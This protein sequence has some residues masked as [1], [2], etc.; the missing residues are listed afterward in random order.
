M[1]PRGAPYIGWSDLLAAAVNCVVPGDASNAQ[2]TIEALWAPN[3]VACLSV[4]SGLDALFQVLALPP[5]SEIIVSAITIPHIL[6]IIAKHDLIA[7]PIDVDMD[8][9]AVDADAVRGAVTGKTKA[10][11]V[12]HLFGSRMPLDEIVAVARECQLLLIEDCAQAN[13]GSAYRGHPGSDVSMFSFGFIKRQTA[14]GGGLLRFKSA[15]LADQMRQKQATYSRQTRLSY[16]RRV[17][18]MTAMKLVGLRPVF[19]AFVAAVQMARLGSRP[20]ARHRAPIVFWRRSVRAAQATAQRA[21][22]AYARSSPAPA[23]GETDR[24]TRRDCGRGDRRVSGI[25]SFWGARVASHALALSDVD[26]GARA[27]DA[28]PVDEGLRRDACGASKWLGY[29]PAPDGRPAPEHAMRLMT[30]VLY[31]PL[32]SVGDSAR[33]A[34]D[35]G[36]PSRIRACCANAGAVVDDRSLMRW[37]QFWIRAAAGGI[38]FGHRRVVVHHLAIAA[39]VARAS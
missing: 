34:G 22:V 17:L 38:G 20:H 11:L 2:Q 5:S 15:A 30:E 39:D 33:D 13:D 9:L 16:F 8:T 23:G 28:S 3:T 14:L 24:R 21:A 7:V 25:E 10:I 1:I 36:R 18:T 31:L 27:A 6:D 37:V 32:F 35:G 12:A 26:V 19:Q 29:V 4:R